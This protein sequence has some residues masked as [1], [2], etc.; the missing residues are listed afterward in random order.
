MAIVTPGFLRV[1]IV[2]D[3]LV[4]RQSLKI[5]LLKIKGIHV[6]GEAE[7]GLEALHLFRQL[8]PDLIIMDVSM[9]KMGGIEATRFIKAESQETRIIGLSMHDDEYVAQAM[10]EAGAWACINKSYS[11]NQLMET[12]RGCIQSN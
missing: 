5:I 9:P 6:V 3:H 7:N 10:R 2:D 1:L 8:Q 12:I 4:F 11:P